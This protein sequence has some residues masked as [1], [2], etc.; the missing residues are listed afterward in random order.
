MAAST[1][2]TTPEANQTEEIP[3][4]HVG[5]LMYD[6]KVEADVRSP[7]VHAI[8][9]TDIPSRVFMNPK[10]EY[11]AAITNEGKT[12]TFWKMASLEV[13]KSDQL[14]QPRHTRT[15]RT[16]IDAFALEPSGIRY[17]VTTGNRLYVFGFSDDA[18]A[19]D[20][21]VP[22]K[23]DSLEFAD[24]HGL[25]VSGEGTTRLLMIKNSQ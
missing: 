7:A 1:S 8:L 24:D 18:M 14:M 11:V 3:L 23:V 12:V 10:E 5:L 9:S 25:I 17:A 20:D 2:G 15:F 6:R 13:K 22:S 4:A 21:D 19:S 16:P